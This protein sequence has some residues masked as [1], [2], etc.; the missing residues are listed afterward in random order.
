MPSSAKTKFKKKML[1]DVD[2]LLESHQKLSPTGK[3]R[4]FLGHITR[5][6]VQTLCASWELY[7]E[8]LVVEFA[9]VI[10]LRALTPNE[11]PPNLRIKIARAV[12]NDKNELAPLRL[13][14]PGWRWVYWNE[15][16]R[17]CSLLNSPKYGNLET[18]FHKCIDANDIDQN[19]SHDRRELNSFVNLRGEIA[20]KGA[21]TPYVSVARLKEMR[22]MIADLV[23]QTDKT[24]CEHL[25]IITANCTHIDAGKLPWRRT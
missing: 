4:R 2:A 5:A 14:E 11:L 19:W 18:L 23:A 10:A 15:V 9:K 7:I 6:G 13:V 21:D 17:L 20:H 24:I 25:R 16:E 3:G 12:R 1:P 8:E 22:V